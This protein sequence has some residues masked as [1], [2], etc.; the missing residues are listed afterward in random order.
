MILPQIIHGF[1]LD[2][3]QQN[4]YRLMYVPLNLIVIRNYLTILIRT[5]I[6]NE[7]TYHKFGV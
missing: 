2:N 6:Y 1:S 7:H 3:E 4:R 5:L